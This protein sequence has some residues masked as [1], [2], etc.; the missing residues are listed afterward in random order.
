MWKAPSKIYPENK[1]QFVFSP[2]SKKILEGDREWNF[3]LNKLQADRILVYDSVERRY[4]FIQPRTFFSSF[5]LNFINHVSC[6][7]DTRIYGLHCDIL[8]V[9]PE[10]GSL[11]GLEGSKRGTAHELET[12]LACTEVCKLKTER[13][14]IDNKTVCS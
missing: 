13:Q 4:F 10:H 3:V 11:M 2:K 5:S 1:I 8:I 12:L 14:V 6:T 7:T 9:T